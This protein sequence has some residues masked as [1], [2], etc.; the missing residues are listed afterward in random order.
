MYLSSLLI[1]CYYSPLPGFILLSEGRNGGN[2]VRPAARKAAHRHF[3]VFM[4]VLSRPLSFS[5]FRSYREASAI[6]ALVTKITQHQ[7]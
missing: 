4:S 5:V 2:A 3:G 7:L 1:T 6:F